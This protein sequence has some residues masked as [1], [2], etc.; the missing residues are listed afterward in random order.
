MNLMTHAIRASQLRLGLGLLALCLVSAGCHTAGEQPHPD[1]AT[2][3]IKDR[4]E[5]EIRRAAISVFT[6]AKYQIGSSARRELVFEKAGSTMNNIL[7]GGISASNAR[8]W[9]RVR[10]TFLPRTDG[11]VEVGCNV[12]RVEN[13]GEGFFEEEKR[14]TKV[15]AKTYQ[16]FLH[17][18]EAQLAQTPGPASP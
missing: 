17:K 15:H 13:L 1:L 8:V 4:T 10:L 3:T 14:L 11:S 18:I 6:E 16:G 9:E 7:Y 5:D 2:L 12:F